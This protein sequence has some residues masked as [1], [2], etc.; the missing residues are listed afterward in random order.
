M[1]MAEIGA[2][3]GGGSNRQALSDE[4]AAGRELFEGWAREAGCEITV[5]RVGNLFARRA[6][7]DPSRPPV[8]VGSHLDTQPTG[9]RF[10]GVYGVLGGLEVL[11]RLNDLGIETEA[12]VEVAVWTNEEGSRFQRSMMGSG[13]WAGV[14]ELEDTYDLTDVDGISVA[15]E[16]QRLGWVG[17]LPAEPRE[18][19]AS[20]ELHIEQGPILETDELE[21]GVVTGVQGLRWFD[22][23]LEGF[24]AHA[25]P[26]PMSGR[27]DPARAIARI[28]DGVYAM[29][30][31]LGPWARAT[32]AQFSSFPVSPNTIPLELTCSLDLRHP[33]LDV[34]D[35]L[36]SGL[37][38]IV[39]R[40]AGLLGVGFEITLQN[41][42]PP[43]AFDPACIEAVRTSVDGLGY[44]H[45]DIVSGAGH[46]ACYVAKHAP[47]A[48]VF[49]PCD[50][51]LSHNEAERISAAQAER[52]ASV[53]LG[54][55]VRTA[56]EVSG[57]PTRPRQ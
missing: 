46:D 48:M 24:P 41:D 3:E 26:T 4:D 32:F 31:E 9:G 25:G 10:D 42:S 52:G 35:R 56:V 45:A 40:E 27:R 29:A 2:T 1:A 51:G 44:S 15:D 23:R 13:V 14:F 39:A 19:T 21:V 47:T 38:E 53:L 55:V 5:D 33:D 30:D 20:F 34:L 17:E 18:L 37:R 43:V 49:V 8:L 28:I 12:P 11:E 36:E 54:A 57:G 7:R 6:G 16:L 50:D 22:I